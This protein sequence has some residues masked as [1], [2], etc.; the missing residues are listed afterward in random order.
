[1]KTKSQQLAAQIKDLGKEVMQ[2][3]TDNNNAPT[4]DALKSVTEKRAKM[5]ELDKERLD[6]VAQEEGFDAVKS[7]LD[8]LENPGRRSDYAPGEKRAQV[9]SL[10]DIVMEDDEFKSWFT[11]KAAAG[12]TGHFRSPSVEGISLKTLV[13]GSSDTQAGAFVRPDYDPDVVLP[14]RPNSLRQLVTIGTT[15]SDLVSFVRENLRVNN[16]AV[17]PEA[18][19][20]AG[21]SGTAPESGLGF[22]QVEAPVQD[23]ATWIPATRRALSDAGQMR[24]L[25]DTELRAMVAE[26]FEDLIWST[27]HATSGTNAQPWSTDKFVTTRKAI[28]RT[29]VTG[30]ATP[31]GWV[32]HPND[33][34][35]FELE[36][37]LEGRFYFGGPVGDGTP[38]LWNLPVNENLAIEQGIA[39]TGDLR[40]VKVWDRQQTQV[41]TTDT[42]SDF[43]I[44]SI[45]VMLCIMRAAIGVKRPAALTE[46]NLTP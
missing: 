14:Q 21:S 27:I 4:G 15:D 12:L 33:W 30:R 23:I 41:F 37:D 35:A 6:A 11:K 40:T 26:K 20:T 7:H 22:E 39:L 8:R 46:V 43:F 38:R 32:M 16:A 17:V 1:M 2:I 25:I 19:A 5:E 9:K 44:R 10:A 18:T 42:H 28:T 36:K 24:T 31:N 3:Y 29:K 34:E 13:T 45:S